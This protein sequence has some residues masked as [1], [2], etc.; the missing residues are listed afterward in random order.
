MEAYPLLCRAGHATV[1]Q[2][3]ILARAANEHLTLYENR[4]IY[5]VMATI[6]GRQTD[7]RETE[8]AVA[9][10]KRLLNVHSKAIYK[11][12]EDTILSLKERRVTLGSDQE[13]WFTAPWFRDVAYVPAHKHPRRSSTVK[14]TLH[15]DLRAYLLRPLLEQER[16]RFN[17]LSL[18][19]LLTVPTYTSARIFEILFHDSFGAK[20]TPLVYELNDLKKRLGIEGKYPKFAD[21]RYIL[22]RG[23]RDLKRWTRIEY[24][25]AGIRHGLAYDH[26]QFEVRHNPGFHPAFSEAV[27]AQDVD[28]L[29]RQLQNMGFAGD[30]YRTVEK[31]GTERVRQNLLAAQKHIL[32]AASS[33]QPIRD[34]GW[35]IAYMIEHNSA[36]RQA[37]EQARGRERLSVQYIH[38]I[39]AVLESNYEAE[40]REA[41]KTLIDEM[42]DTDLERLHSLMRAE[43]DSMTLAQLHRHNWT[44][45]VY[46]TAVTSVIHQKQRF[47]LPIQVQSFALW[48][49]HEGLLSAFSAEERNAIVRFAMNRFAL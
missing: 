13:G 17:T 44:G 32:D 29:V 46:E 20:K 1:T 31:Y 16:L 8:I 36:E 10:L 35:L 38:E 5:L 11:L 30:A 3:N 47:L 25:Y 21:F 26:V 19:E 12:T 27:I 43:L 39:A 33:V 45:A 9:D 18:S 6:S 40:V 49:N 15:D 22:D 34:P 28:G 2:G 4:L 23:M 14:L 7:F 41:V 42:S 37:R 48:A 24:E